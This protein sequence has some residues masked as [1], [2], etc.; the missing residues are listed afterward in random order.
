MKSDSSEGSS[1]TKWMSAV[2]ARSERGAGTPE[3]YFTPRLVHAD[4]QLQSLAARIGGKYRRGALDWSTFAARQADKAPGAPA[5]AALGRGSLVQKTI[6]GLEVEVTAHAQPLST[7][8]RGLRW[9]VLAPRV[10]VTVGARASRLRLDRFDAGWSSDEEN[11]TGADRLRLL[12]ARGTPPSIPPEPMP[13]AVS[14]ARDRLIE[15]VS[16]LGCG[17]D[18]V[19]AV[20]RPLPRGAED[21]REFGQASFEVEALSELIE[22]AR[23]FAHALATG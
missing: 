1:L 8:E 2:F 22:R 11:A 12:R 5:A 17:P 15:R 6:H 18:H 3:E 23:A 16:T 20:G 14:S 4:R 19:F 9:L 7:G 13:R 21:P 10:A